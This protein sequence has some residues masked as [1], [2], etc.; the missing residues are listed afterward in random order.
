MALTDSFSL[1]LANALATE[2]LSALRADVAR[3]QAQVNEAQAFLASAQA[4]LDAACAE[5]S[6][7]LTELLQRGGMLAEDQKVGDCG[8][9]VSSE[10][11]S[12]PVEAIVA[13]PVIDLPVEDLGG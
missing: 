9:A 12:I 6:D 1:S 5:H 10:C 3:A 7:K 11:V 8:L 13:E 2:K 4:K